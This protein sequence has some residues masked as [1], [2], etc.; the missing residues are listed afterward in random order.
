MCLSPETCRNNINSFFK[1]KNIIRYKSK[2]DPHKLNKKKLTSR[3]N[4]NISNPKKKPFKRIIPNNLIQFSSNNSTSSNTSNLNNVRTHKNFF[5]EYEIGLGYKDSDF[6]RRNLMHFKKQDSSNIILNNTKDRFDNLFH[7]YKKKVNTKAKNSKKNISN[8]H[9]RTVCKNM[10]QDLLIS[11]IVDKSVINNIS[12]IN[13]FN[14]VNLSSNR[15]PVKYDLEKIDKI[16]LGSKTTKNIIYN[17]NYNLNSY[18]EKKLYNFPMTTHYKNIKSLNNINYTRILSRHSAKNASTGNIHS[19]NSKN[20]S[21]S[22]K[23]NRPNSNDNFKRNKN[24]KNSK[25]IN[26]SKTRDKY[27]FNSN[28]KYK[29]YFKEQKKV[30]NDVRLNNNK[31]EY[32]QINLFNN[33]NDGKITNESIQNFNRKT[34]EKK[35]NNCKIIENRKNNKI[36]NNDDINDNG[37]SKE[38][39]IMNKTFLS[40]NDKVFNENNINTPE[41]NHFQAITYIQLIKKNNKKFS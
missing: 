28:N 25:V 10:S 9:N 33:G 37:E 5:N 35:N 26:L 7:K 32:V 1:E 3:N 38:N 2:N 4:E 15:D 14:K 27:L 21:N 23:L 17:Y 36:I 29:N 40:F 16:L 13:K 20:K 18:I 41:E 19:K 31:I 6:I 24:T 34:F 30:G 8:I 12:N 22:T 11:K 39:L